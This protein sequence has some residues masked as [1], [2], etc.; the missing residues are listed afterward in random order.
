MNRAEMSGCIT[1]LLSGS[2]L[3][4]EAATQRH[5]LSGVMRLVR[6]Q[7]GEHTPDRVHRY[8]A[9]QIVFGQARDM[10]GDI[11]LFKTTSL[12]KSITASNPLELVKVMAYTVKNLRRCANGLTVFR[13]FFQP[14]K[15]RYT[16]P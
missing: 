8:G 13:Q 3:Q 16:H 15:T 10:V 6:A 7:E 14:Q 1:P 2:S 5:Q 11:D 4:P 12:W 9:C